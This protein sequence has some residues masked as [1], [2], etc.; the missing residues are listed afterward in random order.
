M[1]LMLWGGSVFVVVII[2]GRA[3][4]RFCV[5]EEGL[6]TSRE[7]DEALSGVVDHSASPTPRKKQQRRHRNP[8]LYCEHSGQ[9][10][11]GIEKL[12]SMVFCH[13]IVLLF[14]SSAFS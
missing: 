1:R 4:R 6:A 12:F 10:K 5:M 13:D 2:I 11:N 9:E 8:S 7:D 14:R 3:S